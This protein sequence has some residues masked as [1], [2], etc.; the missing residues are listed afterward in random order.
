MSARRCRAPDWTHCAYAAFPSIART[1]LSCIYSPHRVS[2]SPPSQAHPP[3]P[4]HL[5]L[6]PTLIMFRPKHEPEWEVVDHKEVGQVPANM[7]D[8]GMYFLIPRVPSTD[9]LRFDLDVDVVS[10]FRGDVSQTFTFDAPLPSTSR[11]SSQSTST[12]GS[13]PPPRRWR[14]SRCSSMSSNHFRFHFRHSATSAASASSDSESDASTS[15]TSSIIDF[16][17]SSSQPGFTTRQ[18]QE[19]LKYARKQLIESEAFKRLGANILFFEG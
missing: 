12:S 3:L 1:P 16:P 19:A 2:T 9:S 8:N 13:P 6:P 5:T 18:I 14:F 15:T 11:K 10:I 4:S 17:T 7:D